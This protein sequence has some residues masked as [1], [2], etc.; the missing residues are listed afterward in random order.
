MKYKNIIFDL[1]NTLLNFDIA[2]DK[3]L[4]KIIKDFNLEYNEETLQIYRSINRPLWRKLESGELSRDEVFDNRFPLFLKEFGIETKG[5]ATELKFREY[6]A[7]FGTEELPNARFILE[8]LK[9]LNCNIY[10]ATNGFSDVQNKRLKNS[11]FDTLFDDVFISESIGFDKPDVNFFNHIFEKLNI[12]DKSTFL[13]IGDNENSDIKGANN[14]NIDS[15]LYNPGKTN[16]KT[17]ATYIISD[18]KE[19][20]TIVED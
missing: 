6:L 14:S 16:V 3:A 10:L 5:N 13:M 1:D 20:L 4:E 17:D 9:K 11:H 12:E 7:L 15:V 2:E 19:I 8:E 18:L